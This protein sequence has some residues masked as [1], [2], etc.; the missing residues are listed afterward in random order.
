LTRRGGSSKTACGSAPAWQCPRLPTGILGSPSENSARSVR[1]ASRRPRSG[2]TWDVGEA[3]K[4]RMGCHYRELRCAALGIKSGSRSRPS[5]VMD[6]HSVFIKCA[7]IAGGPL[8]GADH[9]AGIVD[10]GGVVLSR[11]D[12]SADSTNRASRQR[13]RHCLRAGRVAYSQDLLKELNLPIPA[14]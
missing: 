2:L 6:V 13:R 11:R 9:L 10:S 3:Q 1:P 4:L 12:P 14:S 8:G 7:C 5:S